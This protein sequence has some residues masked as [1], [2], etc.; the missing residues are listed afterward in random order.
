MSATTEQKP[1]GPAL[2]ARGERIID[3]HVTVLAP[4]NQRRLTLQREALPG[5]RP[6][7]YQRSDVARHAS[8]PGFDA[9]ALLVAR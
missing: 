4:P 5:E 3:P 8:C 7:A 1:G 2:P 9:R 6:S